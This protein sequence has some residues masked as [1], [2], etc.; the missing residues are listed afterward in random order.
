MLLLQLG[1]TNDHGMCAPMSR[2]E[3]R[4]TLHL[5]RLHK[6]R[7]RPLSPPLLALPPPLAP[8]GQMSSCLLLNPLE[9]C[10]VKRARGSGHV[11]VFSCH[12][13]RMHQA[14]AR[15]YKFLELRILYVG[16]LI[17]PIRIGPCRHLFCQ[18]LCKVKV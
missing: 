9:F 13:L 15:N 7:Y 5:P 1:T 2:S 6:S 14:I 8:T 16:A 3:S 11:H 10:K 18:R 17:N 12:V 4:S